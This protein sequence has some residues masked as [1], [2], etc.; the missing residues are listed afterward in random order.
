LW[1]W[2]GIISE[3]LYVVGESC[4]EVVEVQRDTISTDPVVPR[5]TSTI[6]VVLQA[7]VMVEIDTGPVA[8]VVLERLPMADLEGESCHEVVEVQ[9]DTIST[10]PVVPRGNCT[11]PA[12]R[13]RLVGLSAEE[14][15]AIRAEVTDLVMTHHPAE[16]GED[17][18]AISDIF[19]LTVVNERRQ[20]TLN[21][22]LQTLN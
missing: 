20:D 16:V 22:R 8:L 9:R 1:S 12:G 14:R 18:Q 13:V 21:L 4:H 6:T 10:D 2:S 7:K 15:A 3:E 17:W 11:H 19:P 5:G